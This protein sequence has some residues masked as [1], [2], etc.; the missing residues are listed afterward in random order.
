MRGFIF[1]IFSL[2]TLK[3]KNNFLKL[4]KNSWKE[5][6]NRIKN[7]RKSTNFQNR[8]VDDKANNSQ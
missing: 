1:L 2:T 7:N 8:T 4:I 6:G 3:L 5:I